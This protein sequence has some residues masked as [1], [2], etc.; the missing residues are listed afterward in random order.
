MI[1][2]KQMNVDAA[3]AGLRKSFST[4]KISYEQFR[5]RFDWVE[6]Q[7]K[8]WGCEVDPETNLGSH[9]MKTPLN[10]QINQTIR[11]INKAIKLAEQQHDWQTFSTL[12]EVKETL[13]Q[14]KQKTIETNILAFSGPNIF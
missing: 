1:N 14:A 4:K 5:K 12:G 6:A 3:I 2:Q 9:E 13:A 7:A 10:N 8:K 11:N